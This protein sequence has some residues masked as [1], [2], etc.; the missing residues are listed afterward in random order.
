ML[1]PLLFLGT[2]AF[3]ESAPPAKASVLVSQCEA[4]IRAVG[5]NPP[6]PKDVDTGYRCLSYVRGFEDAAAADVCIPHTTSDMLIRVYLLF[7]ARDPKYADLERRA[8]LKMAIQDAFPC[9][10]K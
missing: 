3:Q 2:M 4:Y 7:M 8:S 9:S 6:D 1:A 5:S 10:R